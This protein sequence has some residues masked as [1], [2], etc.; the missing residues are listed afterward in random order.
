MSFCIP[1]F[2]DLFVSHAHPK[3]NR[4]SYSVKTLTKLCEHFGNKNINFE[5]TY[6]SSQV[7][8]FLRVNIGELGWIPFGTDD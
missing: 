5:K 1:F 6:D 3:S 2:V 4:E 8:A 7:E